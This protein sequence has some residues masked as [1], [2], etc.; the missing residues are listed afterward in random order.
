MLVGFE[1]SGILA[2]KEIEN[3]KTSCTYW[4][5]SNCIELQT[6]LIGWFKKPVFYCMAIEV[7]SV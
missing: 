5:I 6:I 2:Q 3:N 7:A 1:K 4:L